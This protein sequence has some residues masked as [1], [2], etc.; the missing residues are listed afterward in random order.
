VASSL[1]LVTDEI[2]II[3][4]SINWRLNVPC[5]HAFEFSE[6]ERQVL[7][8]LFNELCCQQRACQFGAK[9]ILIQIG[10]SYSCADG[11]MQ[12]PL[13]YFRLMTAAVASFLEESRHSPSELEAITGSPVSKTI[14]LLSRMQTMA[15]GEH[16]CQGEQDE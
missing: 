13:R 14:E 10:Q 11:R 8:L 6:V 15:Y 3:G 1:S 4:H 2:R 12:L 9:S 16:E 7:R 5:G